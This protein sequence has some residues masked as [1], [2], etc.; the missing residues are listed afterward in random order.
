MLLAFYE[1]FGR[2]FTD[3]VNRK[4]YK[5]YSRLWCFSDIYLY[6]EGLDE[7][8]RSF[9]HYLRTSDHLRWAR[10]I[11]KGTRSFACIFAGFS[12]VP[13]SGVCAHLWD[14][15]KMGQAHT[16]EKLRRFAYKPLIYKYIYIYRFNIQP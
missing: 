15:K 3:L 14:L 6:V 8:S 10:T 9:A 13:F 2:Y 5:Q 11:E 12:Q 16:I 7:G 4:E 1:I